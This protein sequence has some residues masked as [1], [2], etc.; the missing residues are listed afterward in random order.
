MRIKKIAAILMAAVMAS[1]Q[2]VGCGSAGTSN[3]ENAPDSGVEN[4]EET[5]ELVEL[6]MLIDT[7]VTAAGLQ[8]VCDLAEEK[9][10]IHVTIET[11]P[12]GA[13]GDNIVKTRLAS[14]DMADLCAYNSGALLNALNPSEYFIDLTNEEWASRLDDTYKSTVTVDGAVYGIPMSSTQAGAIIYNKDLY[15]KYNLTVPKTW[16]EFL[17]NCKVLKDA[18]ETAI[19]AGYSDS[20]TAQVPFL[21]E[22]YNLIS[23][24]PN[25]VK[26]LEAGKAKYAST[27]AALRGFE[28]LADT[29]QFYN[30]DYLATSYDDACDMIANGEGVHWIILTQAMSN[31]FELYGDDVNKLG[32]FGVPGDNADDQGLTVWMPTSIYGNKNTDKVDDIKRFMEFY[33]SDEALDVYTSVILPDGP[34]C[35][36]GYQLPENAYEA[37]ANDMQAYFDA[38]KTEVAM[39]FLTPVKGSNCPSI[40]QELGS[41]QTTPEEAAAKYDEDCYKQAIQLGLDW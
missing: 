31:I 38:G 9:L 17:A 23:A 39:E 11:R 36:K 10:G 22:N 8:A 41:G 24:A 16:D 3:A 21:G 5:Q 37:V 6:T 30:A 25:F 12:G 27:P 18:G 26:E 33:I 4:K 19:I 20:W 13:D 28:K 15:A 40:C 14:G 1:V 29:T 7:D 2:L 34:Y 32:I 35:V